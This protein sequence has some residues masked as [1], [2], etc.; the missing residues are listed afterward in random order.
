MASN[1]GT[2]SSSPADCPVS[3]HSLA[4]LSCMLADQQALD[5]A[6]G[7]TEGNGQQPDHQ[8]I[9]PARSRM[10]VQALDD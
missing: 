5:A 4:S 9:A 8:N 3:V 10:I 7:P 6:C 1:R 2:G